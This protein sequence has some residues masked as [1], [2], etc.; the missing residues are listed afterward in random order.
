MAHSNSALGQWAAI[1]PAGSDAPAIQTDLNAVIDAVEKQVNLQYTTRALR[2]T[3]IPSPVNG[4][5][6]QILG[7]VNEVD[8]RING[9]W[10]KI[11]PLQYSGTAAPASGLG[12]VGDFYAQ[13]S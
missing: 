9:A 2:D 6:T 4:M 3:A 13:Y 1:K 8:M 12:V 7:T 5:L 11:Y 10:V